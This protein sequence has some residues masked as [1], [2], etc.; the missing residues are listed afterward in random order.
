MIAPDFFDAR[1]FN[2]KWKNWKKNLHFTHLR[3]WFKLYCNANP[4]IWDHWLYI[5][6]DLTRIQNKLY[7]LLLPIIRHI[8]HEL[9]FVQEHH[10][11]SAKLV[12]S[13]WTQVWCCFWFP[14]GYKYWNGPAA[15]LHLYSCAIHSARFYIILNFT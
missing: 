5:N 15:V 4:I 6:Q 8:V 9:I 12:E 13:N 7:R 11:S 10:R 2:L 1:N 3:Q 14:F